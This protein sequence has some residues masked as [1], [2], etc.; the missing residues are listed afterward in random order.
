MSLFPAVRRLNLTRV[1][2]Q[3][4]YEHSPCLPSVTHLY[5]SDV[6]RL[7]GKTIAFLSPTVFP[8]LTHLSSIRGR[9]VDHSYA[10]TREPLF[11]LLR[12]L[13]SLHIA[14]RQDWLGFSQP[15]AWAQLVSLKHLKV[16][17][18]V[19]GTVVHHA[20]GILRNARPSQGR[21]QTLSLGASLPTQL[22]A[23]SQLATQAFERVGKSSVNILCLPKP[24]RFDDTWETI[25]EMI[26][27]DLDRLAEV[28]TRAGAR[29]E[30]V[31]GATE[32]GGC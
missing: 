21:L 31:E 4:D 2:L 7:F 14:E 22:F 1:E 26:R 13:E 25:G 19:Q 24:G 29:V 15:E 17:E 10:L 3:L 6:R 32:G 28:A 5:L 12:Q 20:L 18:P 16:V 8:S 23:L 27:K 30:W 11:P 9:V